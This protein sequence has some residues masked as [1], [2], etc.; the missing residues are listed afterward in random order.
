MPWF[1]PLLVG[2]IIGWLIEW[3][4][5]WFF[6]RR[7]AQQAKQRLAE[8]DM[9]IASLRL[10]LSN[11]REA[12]VKA[13]VVAA[14]PEP[15]RTVVAPAADPQLEGKLAAAEAT[16]NG[17]WARVNEYQEKLAAA[18]T[19]LGQ[20]R[21]QAA[22]DQQRRAQL[23]SV[24]AQL[25]QYRKQLAE[26][27]FRHSERELLLAQAERGKAAVDNAALGAAEAEIL[28]LQREVV[29]IKDELGRLP[30]PTPPEDDIVR[31]TGIGPV[32]AERLKAAGVKT[33]KED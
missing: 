23:A 4:I 31:I 15:P 19:E 18:E 25:A 10:E 9:E 14:V 20:L 21:V 33:F 30:P 7:P 29:A 13:G 5:D 24:Q 32:F 2:L 3:L 26:S 16:L 11:E 27:Q 1:I 17:L 12:R 6:W 28:R 8:A 22:E